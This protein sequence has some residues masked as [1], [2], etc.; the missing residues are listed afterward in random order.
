MRLRR[1]AAVLVLC[2]CP[3]KEPQPSP[4]A[5]PVRT[6]HTSLE[7]YRACFAGTLPPPWQAEVVDV[8]RLEVESRRVA[9][10]DCLGGGGWNLE[11][12]A[13]E[14]PNGVFE[15]QVCRVRSGT[16]RPEMAF[17]R[18]RFSGGDEATASPTSPARFGV[19][20]GG[21]CFLTPEGLEAMG[22]ELE[23][24][25][26]QPLTW[27]T[28]VPRRAGVGVAYFST[29][30]DGVF[31]VFK[32]RGVDGALRALFVDLGVFGPEHDEREPPPRPAP[33]AGPAGGGPAREVSETWEK[34]RLDEAAALAQ[35]KVSTAPLTARVGESPLRVRGATA[36]Q[37][38]GQSLM[39]RLSS[40]AGVGCQ[41]PQPEEA[42]DEQTLEFVLSPALPSH[43][44]GFRA[45]DPTALVSGR[46]LGTEV[47]EP[48]VFPAVVDRLPAKRGERLRAGV[49]LKMKAM[50]AHGRFEA[51]FCGD[52]PGLPTPVPQPSVTLTVDGEV[53]AVRGVVVVEQP[54]LQRLV[55]SSAGT[56][57]DAMGPGSDLEVQLRRYRNDQGTTEVSLSGHRLG[58][59]VALQGTP[60]SPLGVT[61]R[62][63]G[64]LEPGKQVRVHLS[65]GVSVGGLPVS[66]EGDVEALVCSPR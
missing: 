52:E 43:G 34:K 28:M 15:V 30:G 56:S 40:R 7:W 24:F 45:S 50:E 63:L 25:P 44:G 61:W 39:V 2:A 3:A 59:G 41:W 14:V 32:T 27:G 60:R 35:V 21:G 38:A 10:A 11:P 26:N 62:F 42:P 33:D 20:S 29:G 49:E 37:R 12:L 55:L 6:P 19:D 48:S 31:D 46:L 47:R 58:R 53:V 16:Q 65:G 8:G 18:L 36:W 64:P 4:V 17:A 13:D 57:C 22:P 51:T 23:R 1:L 5:P 9:A 54:R 66:L